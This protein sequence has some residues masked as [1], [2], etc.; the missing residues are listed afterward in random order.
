MRTVIAVLMAFMLTNVP[1]IAA[2]EAVAESK[3][4]ATTELVS[5]LT[6]TQAEEKVANYLQMSEVRKGLEARGISPDEVSL[7]I[8][9]LSDQE[10]K[11]LA[12]QMDQARYGGDILIAILVVV[13]IIFLIKRM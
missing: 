1:H 7:R 4:A 8:A 9:S 5:E 13:L 12:E 6:R 10:L 11:Q 3:L 2:A